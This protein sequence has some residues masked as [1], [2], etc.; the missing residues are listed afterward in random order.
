MW[1]I[2]ICTQADRITFTY[3]FTSLKVCDPFLWFRNQIGKDGTLIVQLCPSVCQ[4]FT[5]T[6]ANQ[7]E[8]VKKWIQVNLC[9]RHLSKYH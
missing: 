8:K 2:M 7:A 9:L 6:Y 5:Y 4:H 3:T 1:F